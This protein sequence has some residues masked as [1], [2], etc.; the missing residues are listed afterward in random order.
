MSEKGGG[1]QFGNIGGNVSQSAGGDI[2]GGDITTTTTTTT[3]TTLPA[4]PMPARTLPACGSAG[5]RN[6]HSL[7]AAEPADRLSAVAARAWPQVPSAA[8]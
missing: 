2:V 1:F 3:T 7:P 4:V 8:H 5:R 6:G